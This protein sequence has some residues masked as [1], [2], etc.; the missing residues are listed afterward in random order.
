MRVYVYGRVS[1]E[2]Q[3]LAQ[4]QHTVDNWLTMHNLTAD[5]VVADEGVSGKIG[6]AGRKLG[7]YL[8]P[9]LQEGDVLVVSE[10]SRLG[11]SMSD[12]NIFITTELKPRKVRLVVVTMGIDLDCQRMSAMDELILTNFAFCA[13]LERELISSRTKAKL[14]SLRDE[15]DRRGY[16]INRRG[17]RC[18]TFGRPKGCDTSAGRAVARTNQ[19]DIRLRWLRDSLACKFIRAMESDASYASWSRE[20]KMEEFNKHYYLL[21]GNKMTNKGQY[22]RILKE[23]GLR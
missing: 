22:S 18:T 19:A 15:R 10:V 2:E 16:Y 20:R 14:D 23:L 3:T 7:S 9:K 13:Q 11:R 17:E 8:L 1:T 6:Y 4:Q 5:E 12:L 21:S